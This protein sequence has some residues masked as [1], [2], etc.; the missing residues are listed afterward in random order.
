MQEVARMVDTILS[1]S[2]LY[3]YEY[4]LLTMIEAHNI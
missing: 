4:I 1:N 3:Y 2:E